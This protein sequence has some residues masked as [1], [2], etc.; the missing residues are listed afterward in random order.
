MFLEISGSG[1]FPAV[2]L[3]CPVHSGSMVLRANPSE[4]I[5]E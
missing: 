1:S 4:G 3:T 5:D 2:L